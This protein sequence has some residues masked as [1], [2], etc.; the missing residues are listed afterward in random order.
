MLDKTFY[1]SNTLYENINLFI[2]FPFRVQ[3]VNFCVFN[4]S[5]IVQ[6][7]W[8]L[9]S[10]RY[11]IY[12]HECTLLFINS[13]H[14]QLVLPLLA[15]CISFLYPPQAP[16]GLP[17]VNRP[18]HLGCCPWLPTPSMGWQTIF[19]WAPSPS[20]APHFDPTTGHWYEFLLYES[21]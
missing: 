8:P 16:T 21:P 20:K 14:T 10:Q 17:P 15:R 11:S 5:K 12:H 7:C 9:L 4:D 19:C 6:K 13:L 1:K 3:N 18:C 2:F